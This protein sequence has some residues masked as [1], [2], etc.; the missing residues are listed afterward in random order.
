MLNT[1]LEPGNSHDFGIRLGRITNPSRI[2]SMGEFG[3]YQDAWPFAAA[4]TVVQRWHSSTTRY[5]LLFV[6]GHAQQ[7][8]I[9]K[10]DNG[11]GT[12]YSFYWNK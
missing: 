9:L 1:L 8:E 4:S 2:V 5:N 11:V 10:S 12:D 3:A 7:I 6:D